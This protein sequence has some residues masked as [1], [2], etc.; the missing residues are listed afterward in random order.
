[1]MGLVV[2][3][4]LEGRQCDTPVE[5]LQVPSCLWESCLWMSESCKA[6]WDLQFLHTWRAVV[7][8][9]LVGSPWM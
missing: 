2:S 5:V 1:M 7:W 3:Q 8:T 9:R 4:Q 6:S